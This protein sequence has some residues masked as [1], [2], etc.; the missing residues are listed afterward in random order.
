M[1]EY[2]KHPW[3][4]NGATKKELHKQIDKLHARID[5]LRRA[6][7]RYH[8]DVKLLREFMEQGP[9]SSAWNLFLIN[10]SGNDV[11]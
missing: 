11:N 9:H 5:R 1:T 8:E 10:K 4:T 2:K 6:Q 7:V 3:P